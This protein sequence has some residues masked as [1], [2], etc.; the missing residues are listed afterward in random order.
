MFYRRIVAGTYSRKFKWAIWAAMGFTIFFT[1][2]FLI[3]LFAACTPLTSYWRRYDV[4]HPLTHYHCPSDYATSALGKAAG[5]FSVV[6]DFYSVTLPA[7]LLMR[8][9]IPK[10]QKIGLMFVFS[11]GY[12]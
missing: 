5:A 11:V 3:L 4:L 8:L 9:E 2:A 1:A 6:T 10:R 12:L 7:V